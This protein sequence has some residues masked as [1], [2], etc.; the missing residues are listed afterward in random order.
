MRVQNPDQFAAHV[1]SVG[2]AE[3]GYTPARLTAMYGTAE[4]TIALT[5]RVPVHLVYMNT[6]VDDDGRLVVRPDIYGYDARVQSA[7]KGRYMVVNERSQRGSSVVRSAR[8]S[9]SAAQRFTRARV[10]Q[11]PARTGWH[12]RRSA[13]GFFWGWNPAY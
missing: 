13:V 5:T 4:R 11:Q 2:A 12:E 8:A 1:L 3:G 9:R 10:A 7:L 6:Y